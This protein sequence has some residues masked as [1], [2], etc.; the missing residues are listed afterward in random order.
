MPKTFQKAPKAIEEMAAA[1]LCQ[2]DT[3]KP[4]LDAHVKI[5][6]VFALASRDEKTDAKKGDALRFRG[7]RAL[8]L[9]RVLSLKQRAMGRGDAEITLV[10]DWFNEEST[11][12]E[13]RA[14]LDHELH[15]IAVK[16][17]KMLLPLRDDLNRPRL[18]LRPHDYDFGWFAIIARHHAA[19]AVEVRQAKR[20]MDEAGQWLWPGI[21]RE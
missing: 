19:A 14:L 6:F 2:F 9:A 3:H 4:L 1:I 12:L 21:A 20:I 15:H 16:V 8:G 18:F 13:Q 5:D 7:C 17:N 11:E 10:G